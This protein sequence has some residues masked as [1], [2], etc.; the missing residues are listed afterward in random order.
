MI[1]SL[2]L[3]SNKINIMKKTYS[4]LL[5]TF[6]ASVVAFAQPTLTQSNF[7]PG[8]GDSQLYYVAD[9]NSILDNSSG[10]NAVFYYSGLRGYGQ[11]QTQY[12]VTPASTSNAGD[13]P[14]ATFTDTTAGFDGNLKYNQDFTDSLN[15]IGLVLEI[16]TF[17]TVIAKYDDDPEIFMKFPFNYGDS[18][19]DNYGG[20]FT[21]PAAPLPTKGNG[22]AT[23]TYDAWGTLKLPMTPDID[24]VIRIVR[25]ENLLTDTIFLQPI[26]PDILPIPVNA[27]QISY[28]KPSISKNPLL[29]FVVADVN[30]DTNI[31]VISQYPMFGVGVEEYNENV[32]ITI[33]PNPVNKH[34]T[35]LTF[36]LEKKANVNVALFNNLGQNIEE[37][38]G[39][40]LQQGS[41]SLK[42]KTSALSKGLYFVNIKIGSRTITK[43][44]IIE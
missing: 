18:F 28:Y 6:C 11:T 16:N 27:T 39:G 42:V 3:F 15:V 23:V 36:E 4:L 21:S 14:T 19:T 20:T 26:L 9:T 35:T 24:S 10:P 43:K 30:G 13:Y 38:F 34:F 31:N 37:V 1:Y 12:F 8:I 32:D 22:T 41:N 5:T 40:V 44:L 17:G 29:S 25:V 7:V 33:Y 2:S